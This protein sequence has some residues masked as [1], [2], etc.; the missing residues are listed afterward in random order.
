MEGNVMMVYYGPFLEV[1]FNLMLNVYKPHT[2]TGNEGVD[3]WRRFAAFVFGPTGH[4]HSFKKWG[5][6][7]NRWYIKLRKSLMHAV[8]ASAAQFDTITENEFDLQ[9]G[10]LTG[11]TRVQMMGRRILDQMEHQEAET[12]RRQQIDNNLQANMED[13]EE[14]MHLAPMRGNNAMNDGAGLGI[15][16]NNN[17]GRGRYIHCRCVMPSSFC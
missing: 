11:T 10:E 4:L 16:R 3:A 9:E 6:A 1:L 2:L 14:A 17:V 12:A 5:G 8:T 15:I 7:T 13:A